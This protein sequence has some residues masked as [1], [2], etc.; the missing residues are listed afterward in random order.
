MDV[1]RG[2]CL[3]H[4]RECSRRGGHVPVPLRIH[5]FCC[6]TTTDI[7]PSDIAASIVTIMHAP[8]KRG[9]C[10]FTGR[11]LYDIYQAQH[12]GVQCYN[13][14]RYSI[15]VVSSRDN[16][17]ALQGD[18]QRVQCGQSLRSL[19]NKCLESSKSFSC[20]L[21]PG[22]FFRSIYLSLTSI[23]P[24]SAIKATDLIDKVVF[25]HI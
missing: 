16:A 17:Q 24:S 9:T 21:Y 5:A 7:P 10:R 3:S 1:E 22:D 6:A 13:P 4:V 14:F 23:C 19:R 15:R 12:I 25:P 20:I 18:I 8:F 11:H 2:K